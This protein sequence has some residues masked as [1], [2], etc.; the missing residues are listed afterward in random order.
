MKKIKEEF[1]EF[2]KLIRSMPPLLFAIFILS[3]VLM[4][5]LAN[6][7]I[8]MKSD[9]LALDMGIL[10][11]WISFLMLDIVTK[12]YGLKAANE[13]SIFALLINLFVCL[14]FFVISVIPGVWSQGISV[15]TNQALDYTF[16]GTWFITLGSSVA[17]IISAIVNNTINFAIG[18]FEKKKDGFL[19]FAFRTYV[20]TCIGQFIDNFIFALL[21]SKLFFSWSIVQCLTCSFTG[22]L[23]ELLMEIIFSFG[24]YKILE[25]MERDNVGKEYIE[26]R[27]NRYESAH[28]RDK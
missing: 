27:R 18:K 24:G 4:N 15:E 22:M 10:V 16:R 1:V 9:Y 23:V 6:K 5:I 13:I 7:S 11:S 3:V 28:N 20:S 26:Y 17:F 14:L 12:R 2:K 25:K 8:D 19:S 21:V